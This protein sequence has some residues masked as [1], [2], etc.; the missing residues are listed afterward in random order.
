MLI[1]HPV[2]YFLVILKGSP[3]CGCYI[4]PFSSLPCPFS[5]L[6]WQVTL[7]PASLRILSSKCVY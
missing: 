5:F 7:S 6:S 2:L 3:N 4:P 1:L